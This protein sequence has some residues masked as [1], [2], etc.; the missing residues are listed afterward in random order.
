MA[1]LPSLFSACDQFQFAYPIK[2]CDSQPGIDNSIAQTREAVTDAEFVLGMGSWANGNPK[3]TGGRADC[4]LYPQQVTQIG[5][6]SLIEGT[7]QSDSRLYRCD[8]TRP[9][10]LAVHGGIFEFARNDDRLTKLMRQWVSDIT[11]GSAA[12]MHE[13]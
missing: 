13:N 1:L 8:D 10:N 12:A 7:A 4:S 5:V 3:F 6:T 11:L 9:W 2:V